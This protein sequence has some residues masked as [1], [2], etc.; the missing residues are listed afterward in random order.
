MFKA[1]VS[2]GV[3]VTFA[4]ASCDAIDTVISAIKLPIWVDA[5][6]GIA[7]LGV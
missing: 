4:S 3:G 2:V 7:Y 1:S 6:D 5:V